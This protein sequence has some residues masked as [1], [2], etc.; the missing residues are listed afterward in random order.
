MNVLP[1]PGHAR[2]LDLAAEQAGDLAAD[3]QAQAG[4]AV[5]RGWWC[6]RPAGRPRRSARSLS[7]AMPMPVSL[8]REGH[9]L[10]R[11]GAA[12]LHRSRVRPAGADAA[13]SPPPRSVNLNALESRFFRIC[14]SRC[15]SVTIVSGRSSASSTVKLERR[16]C[17][18]TGRNDL[19]DVARASSAQHAPA[20]GAR[21][22]LPASTFDRSRMSL[23]SAEQVVAGGVDRLRELDLLVGQVAVVVVGQQLGQDQQAVERRAQLVRHVGQ[24]LRLVAAS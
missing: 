24:E 7:A 5:A 18:A 9:H 22:C 6:R 13:A 12:P 11:P 21:P 15:S 17:S 16:C 1:L 10:A 14:C 3:R 2:D 23:I 8:H 4:A 19:L 20:P